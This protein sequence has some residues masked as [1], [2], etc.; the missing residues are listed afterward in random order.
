MNKIEKEILDIVNPS[1]QEMY[2]HKFTSLKD[3][4]SNPEPPYTMRITPLVHILLHYNKTIRTYSE[5][6]DIEADQVLTEKR[7][8]YLIKNSP[9]HYLYPAQHINGATN[10]G[11]LNPLLIALENCNS[12][13]LT[14]KQYN[15][16]I[17]KSDLSVNQNEGYPA[18]I[19]AIYKTYIEN[20]FTISE[21]NLDLLKESAKNF[22]PD[23][24]NHLL[25]KASNPEN[26]YHIMFPSLIQDLREII[27]KQNIIKAKEDLDATLSSNPIKP[28]S[29]K[30]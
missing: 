27:K 21:E 30:I 7:M 23:Y 20:D 14:D 3:S 18:L 6:L 8:D 9:L 26:E 13:H 4:C 11:H 17:K 12:V 29:V 22:P 10:S 16:L 25:T 19:L 5:N 2:G 28:K 15:H 24:M 1:A